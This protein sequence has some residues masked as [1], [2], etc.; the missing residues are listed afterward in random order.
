MDKRNICKYI[1]FSSQDLLSVH[2]FVFE[3]DQ[4][5]MKKEYL[6]KEHRALL[7]TQGS[8]VFRFG[9]I[10]IPFHSGSLV[11]GFANE[12]FSVSSETYCEYMYINFSGAR[13]EELFRRFQITPQNRSFDGFD[14]L[15][16]L[17]KDGLARASEQTIDLASEGVLLYTFSR[18][19]ADFSETNSIV[20]KVVEISEQQFAD[21]DLSITSIAETLSYNSKYLSHVFKQK[22]GMGYSEYLRTL[23]LKYAVMLL[24]HG[25]DSVKNVAILSGFK[26]PF[27]F[28]TVFKKSIGVSPKEYT[29]NLAKKQNSNPES[30]T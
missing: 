5:K 11:F 16:P 3:T 7:V 9:E 24:E 30:N 18:L 1:S 17:W 6:L 19:F 25:I 26:D 23:R 20:N 12:V 22:M 8:G 10:E 2:C 21:P 27:Y 14:G 29:E 13:P 28:S 15:I 4:E